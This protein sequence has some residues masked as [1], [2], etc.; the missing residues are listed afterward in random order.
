MKNLKT[1]TDLD[2]DE[3]R[4]HL[5]K[6]VGALIPQINAMTAMIIDSKKEIDACKDERDKMG[7]L[8]G[9]KRKRNYEKN[10]AVL[11][12]TQVEVRKRLN[13]LIKEVAI[14]GGNPVVPTDDSESDG[15]V[16]DTG[17]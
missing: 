17:F 2:L 8:Q 11:E 4:S 15:F 3:A 14:R 6:E 16:S 5:V 13:L 9:K 7:F 12:E 10:R 1:S